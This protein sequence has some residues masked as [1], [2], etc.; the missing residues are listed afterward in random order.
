MPTI[1]IFFGIIVQMY[2]RDHAPP[3]VHAFYQGQEAL[4]AISSGDIIAGR[5]PPAATRLMQEWIAKNRNGLLANWER[6]TL[7]QPFEK[8]A[9]LDNP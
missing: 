2:W 5:L 4:F 8:I 7:R 1:S 3:H 9:G 6:G